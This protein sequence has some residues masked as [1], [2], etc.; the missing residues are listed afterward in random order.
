M[1]HTNQ[2]A[3]IQFLPS[4]MPSHIQTHANQHKQT[5]TSEYTH[6][7]IL[8]LRATHIFENLMMIASMNE[9]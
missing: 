8:S 1:Q 7:H 2:F 3:T 4:N 5:G 6:A 9:A